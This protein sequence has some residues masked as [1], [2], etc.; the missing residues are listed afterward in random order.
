MSISCDQTCL[1]PSE[2]GLCTCGIQSTTA[3]SPLIV[4][5]LTTDSA[6]GKVF[7]YQV[8]SPDAFSGFGHGMNHTLSTLTEITS[9]ESAL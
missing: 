9:M 6:C 5:Y 7:S 2:D 3:T 4:A 8:S 1:C